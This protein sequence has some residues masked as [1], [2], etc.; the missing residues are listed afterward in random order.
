MWGLEGG[1]LLLEYYVVGLLRVVCGFWI[2]VCY[3]LRLVCEYWIV[4]GGC[5][6]LKI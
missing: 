2:L 1:V 3:F 4:E 6:R 5:L